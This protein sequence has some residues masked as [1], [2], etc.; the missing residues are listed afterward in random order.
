MIPIGFYTQM[1]RS[2]ESINV[3]SRLGRLQVSQVTA[4]SANAIA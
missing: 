3:C 2:P 4:R 1:L